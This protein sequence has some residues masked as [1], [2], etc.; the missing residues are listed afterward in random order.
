MHYNNKNGVVL[1]EEIR[2]GAV[3]PHAHDI[4]QRPTDGDGPPDARIAHLGQRSQQIGQQHARAQRHHR[5]YHRHGGK[6]H[7]TIEAVEQEEVA[8]AHVEAALDAQVLHA[9]GD[10]LCL[11][12]R[13][14][15]RHQPGGAHKD[16]GGDKQG[17]DSGEPHG[18]ADAATDAVG[19]AGS[20]VLGDEGRKGVAEVLHG[21]VGK[22]IDLHRR[23]KGGHDGRTEAVDQALHQEDTE[24]HDRL[25][26]TRQQRIGGQAA[27]RRKI[28]HTVGL[29]QAQSGETAAGIKIKPQ[30]GHRLSHYRSEGRS[31]D[32][33][34]Q[35]EHEEEVEPDVEHHRHE[36]EAEGHHGIAHRTEQEGVEVIDAHRHHAQED[37]EE[38]AARQRLYLGRRVEQA[39]DGCQ[40]EERS[41]VEHQRDAAHDEHG[42]EDAAPQ[43][44]ELARAILHGEHGTAPHAEA[45][46][47][48]R[49]KHNEGIRRSHGSQGIGAKDTPHDERIGHVVALL[50]QVAQHQREG[51]AEHR[52]RDAAFR[53]ISLVQVGH[54]FAS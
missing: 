12:R 26:D 23:G 28:D 24:V 30:G 53:Q 35:N 25:L 48:G 22:G 7:G 46:E 19:A 41:H 18:T 17:E 43:A 15:K 14:E 11:G 5:E 33:H 21:H 32:A 13:D 45:D 6:G 9:D 52:A 36:Q 38:V 44:V 50:Q 2:L 42:R 4:G 1:S 49:D 51:K 3:V 29:A 37:D 34:V 54:G 40:P 31:F 27:D 10:N 20:E 16:E 47:D 8:D 39:D